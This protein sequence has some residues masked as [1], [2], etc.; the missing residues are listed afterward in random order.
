[1]K[2]VTKSLGDKY[3]KRKALVLKIINNYAA[4]VKLV[5]EKIKM[6]LDQVS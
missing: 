3:Y 1:V 5:D 4:E 6:K 2:I